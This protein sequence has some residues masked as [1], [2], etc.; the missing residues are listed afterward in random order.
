MDALRVRP[1]YNP[2]YKLW[3]IN[4]R[5]I[6]EAYL[7]PEIVKIFTSIEPDLN[8]CDYDDEYSLFCNELDNKKQILEQIIGDPDLNWNAKTSTKEHNISQDTN[9]SK[10]SKINRKKV[11][12]VHGHDIGSKET[13]SSFLKKIELQPIVLH[14]QANEGRTIIEKFENYADVSYAIVL[15][16]PD[17]ACKSQ[18]N[19]DS[20]TFRARQNVIFEFGFFIGQLGREKVCGVKVGDIEIPSDYSGVLYV[21]FDSSESW[22][23]G[24]VRELKAAGLE[25]NSDKVF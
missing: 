11:F 17:D 4:T 23:I 24:L 2:K 16:T 13:I 8:E 18:H 6:L 12:L 10:R 14:E 7:D 22:K 19:N 25:L 20:E 3:D 15:L 9:N 1:A 21:D 5:K